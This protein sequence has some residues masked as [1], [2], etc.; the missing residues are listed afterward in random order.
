VNSFKVIGA[1][2]DDEGIE[3]RLSIQG[4]AFLEVIW[5]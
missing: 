5:N 2:A 4:I 1:F 3:M